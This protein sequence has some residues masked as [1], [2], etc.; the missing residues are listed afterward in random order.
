MLGAPALGAGFGSI[1]GSLARA[2]SVREVD[3]AYP[4][5]GAEAAGKGE[6]PWKGLRAG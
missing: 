1:S 5:E 4:M 3:S 2:P 6:L